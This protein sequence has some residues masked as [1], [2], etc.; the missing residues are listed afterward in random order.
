MEDVQ[1]GQWWVQLVSS[2]RLRCC[3]LHSSFEV[4]VFPM[5]ISHRLLGTPSC[6]S[7]ITYMPQRSGALV[8]CG[9]ALCRCSTENHHRIACACSVFLFE[10]DPMA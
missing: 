5:G 4:A 10:L 7:S 2:P 6:S 9:T 3:G 8:C 1:E